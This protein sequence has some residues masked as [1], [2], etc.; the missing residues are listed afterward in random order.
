MSNIRD[1]LIGTCLTVEEAADAC[2]ISGDAAREEVASLDIEP[3]HTCSWWRE[4]YKID[5]DGNCDDCRVGRM[6]LNNNHVAVDFETYYDAELS[7]TTLGSDAYLRHPSTDVYLVSIYDGEQTYTG[8]P[9]DFDW[10]SLDGRVLVSWNAAFD[11]LVHDIL[12]EKGVIEAAQFTEWNCAANLSVFLRFPRALKSAIKQAYNQPVSKDYRKS[13]L[14][15]TEKEMKRAGVWEE[16]V[17]ANIDDAKWTWQFWEDNVHRWPAIERRA[18]ITAYEQCHR[19]LPVDM[20]K[21]RKSLKTLKQ[22]QARIAAALPWDCAAESGVASPVALKEACAAAGIPAPASTSEDSVACREWEKQYGHDYPWISEIRQWRKCNIMR[23]RLQVL[24]DRTRA[25]NIFVYALKYFGAHTGRWTG[26][27]RGGTEEKGFSTQTFS[28]D[29]VLGIDERSHIIAKKGRKLI[30][31]DAAQIEPRCLAWLSNDQPKLAMIRKGITPYEVH[32]RD[33]M[34]WKGGEMKKENKELYQLA[35]IRVLGLGYGC[36]HKKFQV[37]A[38]TQYNYLM[39]LVE[40]KRQVVDFRAKEK[41]IVKLW[42]RLHSDFQDSISN[43]DHYELPDGHTLPCHQIELPS[44]RNLTY[45]NPQW[46]RRSDVFGKKGKKKTKTS[47]MSGLSIAA[48]QTIDFE[49]QF[50]PGDYRME[51]G[52]SVDIGSSLKFFYGGLLTENLVQATARDV[53]NEMM[54][55]VEDH[56]RGRAEVLFHSH[57]EIILDA[58]MSVTPQ[59]VEQVMSVSPDWMSDCPFGAE[60]IESDCYKK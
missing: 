50:N 38:E 8:R 19:G 33:T 18:S 27:S 9:E 39:T 13:A 12:A 29:P 37:F 60:A 57:D 6:I 14:G 53:F 36:G 52:A 30:I 1:Y 44:G 23:N 22:E 3:C 59:E 24:N 4:R 32:A 58:E 5:S 28:K 31:A 15:R 55:R 25:D 20:K 54:I 2:G 21:V 34:N 51:M 42:N 45:F 41:F 11:K 10:R 43:P 7:I 26:G 16:I 48:K 46:A 40:S 17:A 56:F 35:K 49:D 47:P